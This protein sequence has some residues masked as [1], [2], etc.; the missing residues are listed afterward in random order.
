MTAVTVATE[1]LL[2][3]TA[4]VMMVTGAAVTSWL[5]TAHTLGMETVGPLLAANPLCAPEHSNATAA[6]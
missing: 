6:N 4:V 3:S 2:L 5:T 1:T